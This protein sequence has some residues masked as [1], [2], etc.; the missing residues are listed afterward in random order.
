MKKITFNFTGVQTVIFDNLFIENIDVIDSILFKF[1]DTILIKI[2]NLKV[3][4]VNF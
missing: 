2:Q 4:N 1:P 3:K